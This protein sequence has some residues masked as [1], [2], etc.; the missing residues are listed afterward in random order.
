MRKLAPEGL[1]RAHSR[2]GQLHAVIN[3]SLGW[4]VHL[5]QTWHFLLDTLLRKK[6][7]KIPYCD[8]IKPSSLILLNLL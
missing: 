6:D 3:K 5:C 4:L 2:L 7:L 8:K 1:G